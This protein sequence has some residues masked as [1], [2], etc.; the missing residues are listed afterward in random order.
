[1][2]HVWNT[3]VSSRMFSQCTVAPQCENSQTVSC[4]IKD[5]DFFSH[6]CYIILNSVP[7]PAPSLSP[8]HPAF[9]PYPRNIRT[10]LMLR[11]YLAHIH[12]RSQGQRLDHAETSMCETLA[13]K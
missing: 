11:K 9:I 12:N 8:L 4:F 7:R 6:C 10:A 2:E 1:M 3:F 5:T 13:P